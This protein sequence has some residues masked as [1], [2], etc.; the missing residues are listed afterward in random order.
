MTYGT[1]RRRFS[2]AAL[3]AFA[4]LLCLP[5]AASAQEADAAAQ[6]E[7]A[8]LVYSRYIDVP[9]VGPWYYYA[10]NDPE[11]KESIYETRNGNMLRE[12]GGGGCGPTSL[13]I[14]ISRQLTPQELPALL[15]FRNPLYDSFYYC[16]CSVN[17]YHCHEH[18]ERRS[19]DTAEDFL[20]NLPRALGSIATGNNNL[21]TEYRGD[22]A[23]TSLRL[24]KDVATAYGLEYTTT[25]DWDTARQALADGYSIITTVTKG[26]FTNSSHY[27]VVASTD[28]EWLYL[29]DPLM[30][31]HYENDKWDYLEI[32]EPGL[33]RMKLEHLRHV[34]L[35][36][37]YMI[38]KPIQ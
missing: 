27:M 4:L 8:P 29:L 22:F 38:R 31:E 35:Y 14:A 32:L 17:Q 18:C 30:R 16:S 10:Q 3:L 11:W 25:S 2:L 9:G 20:K 6:E 36:G 15:E 12:F 7:S 33:V 1:R 24:F 37:F 26:V 34:S 19:I 5:L 28:E 23:G 21:Y 13:A